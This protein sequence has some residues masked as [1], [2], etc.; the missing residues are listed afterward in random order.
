MSPPSPA[1]TGVPRLGD[2]VAQL[3]RRTDRLDS[4]EMRIGRIE[5]K[6]DCVLL[7]LDKMLAITAPKVSK[8]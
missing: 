7:S 8:R 5:G 3:A 1:S 4:I 2:D 6:L